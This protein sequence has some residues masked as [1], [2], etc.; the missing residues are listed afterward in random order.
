LIIVITQVM[1]T[2]C[3]LPNYTFV[4]YGRSRMIGLHCEQPQSSTAQH[5][6][7]YKGKRQRCE[8]H[9]KKTKQ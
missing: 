3:Y 6:G 8:F 9:L 1:I 5:C 4:R 7:Y 2:G